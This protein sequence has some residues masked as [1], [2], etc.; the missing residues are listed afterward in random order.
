MALMVSNTVI[1]M[2]DIIKKLG[3]TLIKNF[4]FIRE[5]NR[6]YANCYFFK[7]T[8]NTHIVRIDHKKFP[9][10]RGLSK[11]Q[12]ILTYCNTYGHP[13]VMPPMRIECWGNTSLDEDII[14][15]IADSI[16]SHPN[17]IETEQLI[18]VL[19][20]IHGFRKHEPYI[21]PHIGCM[22]KVPTQ[23]TRVVSIVHK[24]CLR[25]WDINVH[26]VRKRYLKVKSKKY[27]KINYHGIDS[28]HDTVVKKIIDHINSI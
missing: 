27:L 17:N 13:L 19:T 4:G 2:T 16:R 26:K 28:L 8:P 5:P 10:V 23:V 9:T 20:N 1:I 12:W 24:P 11:N 6:E 3:D 22:L 7:P 14:Y 21:G 18:N 15:K 25:Q